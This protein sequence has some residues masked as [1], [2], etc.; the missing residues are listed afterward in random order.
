MHLMVVSDAVNHLSVQ[1]VT[2]LLNVWDKPHPGLKRITIRLNTLP[3]SFGRLVILA[4]P[5]GT[6]E[7]IKPEQVL[8]LAKW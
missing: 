8:P 6:A 5:S 2:G 4:D 7:K 1:D 3:K